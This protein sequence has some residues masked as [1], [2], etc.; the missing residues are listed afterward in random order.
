MTTGTLLWD[1][2]DVADAANAVK[3]FS[4]QHCSDG[5]WILLR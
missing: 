1:R 2:L 4:L 3:H 5:I